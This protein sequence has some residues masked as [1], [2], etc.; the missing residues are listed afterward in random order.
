MEDPKIQGFDGRMADTKA[1]LQDEASQPETLGN[2]LAG[3]LYSLGGDSAKYLAGVAVMGLANMVLLPLYT[4]YL[5]PSDFGLYA[6]IEVLVLGSI[7]VSSL[8]FNV[9]YLKW[10]ASC[11]PDQVAK[12]L[13]T[14]IWV[15]GLVGTGTGTALWIFLASNRSSGILHGDATRFAWALVPLVLFE[16]L[17]GVFLT[18]LRARRRPGAFSVL[19]AVRL[20]SIV[21][22]SIW[23]VVGRGQGL[24]G[25][26]VARVLGDLCACFLA[27]G[28]TASDL[29]LS[30]S[31]RSAL[32][33]A[34]Y[35]LPV[36]GSSLIMMI[37]DG[38]GRFFLNHFGNLEQVGLYAVAIKIS[39]VMRMLVVFPFGAAWGGL[40]FQIAKRPDAPTV[41]SKIMS[42][43]LIL[44]V[45][46]ALVFS[47][48]S[49]ILLLIFATR[50]Y[51]A[52][53][54]LIP[55]LLLVQVV[56]VVQYPSATGIFLGSRTKWLLPI[57]SLG[58]A[59]SLLLN[60][61]L[62]PRF[63]SFGAAW[64]WLVAW[65]VITISMASIGQRYYPLRYEKKAL[66]LALAAC[67]MVVLAS[68]LR[69]MTSWAAGIIV[70]SI[71]ST[72]VMLAATGYV[73]NDVRHF[74]VV[75]SAG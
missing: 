45:S 3:V 18:H 58:V 29:S 43:L 40:M 36:M 32:G 33:M 9:A 15:N 64:A 70:P 60:R 61:L 31:F 75:M 23:L 41:Y 30:A 72:I 12:L 13:G 20:A 19:S 49:P 42:Y 44:S 63:G 55:W 46:F 47:L 37:L 21:G 73:W 10:F 52:S 59:A 6:L 22:W 34:K 5:S 66:L 16:T 56:A 67:V 17:Q 35:G 38:A 4:R 25:V 51:S 62:I 50:Q 39:G 74:G 26:F 14:M 24:T 11:A 71:C 54:P 7:S 8:G 68:H 57:F 69:P 65:L 48:F 1:E 27:W 53:L 28:L 2:S